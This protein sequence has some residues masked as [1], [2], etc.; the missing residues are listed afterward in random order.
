MVVLGYESH[1]FKSKFSVYNILFSIAWK[2]ILAL[3]QFFHFEEMEGYEII[4]GLIY[5][6]FSSW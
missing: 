5:E 3:S 1:M 6:H 2:W 4:Y